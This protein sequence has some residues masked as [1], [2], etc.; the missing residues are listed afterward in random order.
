M[1][2]LFAVL[3]ILIFFSSGCY[4]DDVA[5]ESRPSVVFYNGSY[6]YWHDNV[7]YVAPPGYVY[8]HHIYWG[9]YHHRYYPTPRYGGFRGPHSGFHFR[10]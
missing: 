10:R 4:M 1:T 5:A 7:W 8:G 6:G 2:K 9:P 3:C